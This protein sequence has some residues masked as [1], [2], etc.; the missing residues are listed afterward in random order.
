MNHDASFPRAVRVVFTVAGSRNVAHQF[1]QSCVTISSFPQRDEDFRLCWHP[2]VWSMSIWCWR[3]EQKL[4]VVM[5]DMSV[6]VKLKKKPQKSESKQDQVYVFYGSSSSVKF[7]SEFLE[8]VAWSITPI[9]IWSNRLR[10]EVRRRWYKN[11]ANVLHPA[12]WGLHLK[13]ECLQPQIYRWLNFIGPPTRNLILSPPT[14]LCL[15]F[16]LGLS[17][18]NCKVKSEG[19]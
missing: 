10:Y 14:R 18:T 15:R 19:F 1:F 16:L 11:W 5:Y 4:T 7:K 12:L 6:I 8:L 13:A 2:Q 9:S 17:R 3:Y